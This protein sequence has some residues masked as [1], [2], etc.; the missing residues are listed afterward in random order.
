M[1]IKVSNFR[2]QGAV[3]LARNRSAAA[4]V[5]TEIVRKMLGRRNFQGD[6]RRRGVA[7]RIQ[8]ASSVNKIK[9]MR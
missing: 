3:E 4:A 6:A 2:E 8:R 1:K 9:E 5:A 7:C